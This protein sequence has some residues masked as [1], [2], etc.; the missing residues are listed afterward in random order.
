M[1][2]FAAKDSRCDVCLNSRAVVSENGIHYVCCLTEKQCLDCLMG[3][4]DSYDGYSDMPK[5]GE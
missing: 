3:V 4:K 1:A 2:R 5:K